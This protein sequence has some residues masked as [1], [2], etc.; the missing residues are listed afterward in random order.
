[1][2]E[3]IFSKYQYGI[4]A[5]NARGTI[6]AATKVLVGAEQRPVP[7]YIKPVYPEDNLG[8][9]IRASRSLVTEEYVADSL[10]V[11]RMYYQGLPFFFGCG[12]KGAV[13]PTNTNGVQS[14]T[15][16]PALNT[17][18][19]PDSFTLE[20]GDDTQAYVLNYCLLTGLKI[21][22][23]IAQDGGESPVKIEG[24]YFARRV[25]KQAFTGSLTVQDTTSMTAK[26]ARLYDDDSWA[27]TGTTEVA[28]TLRGFDIELNFGNHPKFFGSPNL[29]FDTHGEGFVDCMLTLTLEGNAA[30][31]DIYDEFRARTKRAVRLDLPSADVIAVNT[32]H[33]MTL[34]VYGDWEK[35]TPLASESNNNNL[36]QALFHGLVDSSLANALALTVVTNTNT[37]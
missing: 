7:D 23:E 17:T 6:V 20:G 10:A 34:D 19:A 25:A 16:T 32:V 13:T 11:P 29:Y 27:N 35:V 22:G 12:L 15:F 14:W 9:R 4:E 28:N 26:L 3:R 2:G 5:A 36:H 33:S 30:A 18:N 21:T 1:M 31:D 37:A 24:A 8:V